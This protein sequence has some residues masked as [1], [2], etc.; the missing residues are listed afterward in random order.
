MTREQLRTRPAGEPAGPERVERPRRRA[1]F[2]TT[3]GWN[4]SDRA[5][6]VAREN[7]LARLDARSPDYAAEHTRR[8]AGPHCPHGHSLNNPVDLPTRGPRRR[9]CRIG[10]RERRDLRPAH[11]RAH[12][13][14]FLEPLCGPDGRS[15]S[16][17]P[18][19]R[20]PDREA[21][22]PTAVRLA[23]PPW[24]PRR[25]A[26][27]AGAHRVEPA[28]P[29]L[30]LRQGGRPMSGTYSD[31]AHARAHVDSAV[32]FL[33]MARISYVG[34]DLPARVRTARLA[35]ID[36][37]IDALQAVHLDENAHPWVE[38]GVLR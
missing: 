30:A 4:V 37:K 13:A 23:L 5:D 28:R 22:H 11:G 26:L 10:D 33:K 3:D 32:R 15:S 36:A 25:R 21:L 38:D 12:T 7:D 9:R 6:R 18:T 1:V 24:P 8:R 17:I 35:A 20:R 27:R 29:P 14:S 16:R 34:S 31:I 19:G 2:G